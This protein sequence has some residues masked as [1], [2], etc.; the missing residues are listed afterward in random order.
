MHSKKFTSSKP[1]AN[2]TKLSPLGLESKHLVADFKRYYGHRLGRDE[3]C[4]SPYYAYEAL[5]LSISDR[6]IERWKATYNA[7]KK[8]DCKRAF[9]LSMEFLMGRTLSNAM[10]NL[11]VT[12]VAKSAMYELGLEIEE[13][14]D[15]EPDAGLGNGGLGRLA[16]C[17]IDSCARRLDR[18]ID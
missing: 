4:R 7:Y 18:S 10:L 16:A 13:L 11:G 12:D 15:S 17:F 5:A 3:N 6:L 14:I 2:I 8:E 9:Y 1:A